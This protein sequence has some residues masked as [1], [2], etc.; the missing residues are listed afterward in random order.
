M[1]VGRGV[2]GFVE[3]FVDMVGGDTV[4]RRVRSDFGGGVGGLPVDGLMDFSTDS[5]AFSRG[6]RNMVVYAS[7]H[8]W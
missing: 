3:L 2:R 4:V 6:F 5:N 1:V 7:R 8:R